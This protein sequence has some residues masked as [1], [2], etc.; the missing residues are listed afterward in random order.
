MSV[1]EFVESVGRRSEKTADAYQRGLD[2][3]ALCHHVSSPDLLVARIKA[4]KL[5]QYKLLDKFVSF[6]SREGYAPKSVWG[7]VSA[8]KSFFGYEEVDL[9][10]RKFKKIVRLPTKMEISL[11]RIPT[12]QE[13]RGLLLNT[14]LRGRALGALLCTSGLR[15]ATSPVR[16]AICS[17]G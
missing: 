8:V 10:D 15:I 12:R 5:N 7:Y 17:M 14:D 2:L 11:D 16:R 9:D 13:V 4:G 3:F 6:L 1:E